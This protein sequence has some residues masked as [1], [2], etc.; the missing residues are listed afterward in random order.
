MSLTVQTL[1]DA[2]ALIADEAHWTKRTLA[3]DAEGLLS[4]HATPRPASGAS[5]GRC[6]CRRRRWFRR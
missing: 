5:S 3:R 2:R 4:P 1:R 6:P